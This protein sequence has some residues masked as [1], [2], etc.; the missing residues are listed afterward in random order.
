MQQAASH[1]GYPWRSDTVQ[2]CLEALRHQHPLGDWRVR[3]L[4]NAK[5]LVQAQAFALP[6]TLAPVRLQ[7][8]A[9]P[10]QQAGSEFVRHKTTR[11]AHYDRFTPT[12]PAV[13]DTVLWNA[14][15]EV[16]ECTRGNVAFLLNG[17]WLT[18]AA[19]CGL[20]PGV[21]R[22]VWLAQG[23]IQESV[24]R[25]SDLPRVAALAF[26]NSLRGWLQA[27]WAQPPTLPIAQGWDSED[28]CLLAPD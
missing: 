9:A 20:L 26:I 2:Q 5:G 13:F 4:L 18:P 15:G 14:A 21:G 8:A 22:S 3:L 27:D 24:I 23:R 25:T 12:D 10:L 11:R 19:A 28:S 17:Q 16:T 6:A 1:F 7:L